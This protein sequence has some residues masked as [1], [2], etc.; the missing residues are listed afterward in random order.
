MVK[1]LSS[2]EE[3]E[4]VRLAREGHSLDEIGRRVARSHHAVLNVLARKDWRT[5]V[6]EWNP[7]S[8]RLSMSE[9]E[10]IRAGLERGE[11][12]TAIAA[13]IGRAVSTVS[14]EVATNAG[15]DEIKQQPYRPEQSRY[16]HANCQKAK[17]KAPPSLPVR[18]LLTC[19]NGHL[20]D[21]PW[22]QF[23]HRGQQCMSPILEMFE[24]GQ[25]TGPD[26][27]FV[28]CISCGMPS[29]SLV[30]AFGENAAGSLPCCRGAA[31]AA[32]TR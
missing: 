26:D 16:I 2:T 22:V 15:R 21:F 18:F 5:P 28:K 1:R 4:V 25:G 30:D 10:E 14:R 19:R 13:R 6:Q 9:R 20:D 24:L 27:V 31:P 3:W 8:S 11:T 23:A 29:R 12:F 32:R 7:S 17:G